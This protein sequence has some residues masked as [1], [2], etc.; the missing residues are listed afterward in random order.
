[1]HSHYQYFLMLRGFRF[2]IFELII[3]IFFNKLNLFNDG[4]NY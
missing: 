3:Q 1:M 4:L 2:S